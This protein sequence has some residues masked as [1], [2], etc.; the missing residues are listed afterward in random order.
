MVLLH[1]IS[2]TL[3]KTTSAISH[4]IYCRNTQEA[5]AA[6]VLSSCYC[7]PV[8]PS[9]HCWECEILLGTYRFATALI[10]Q[11]SPLV[12][13]AVLHASLCSCSSCY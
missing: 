12:D 8:P 11:V 7:A 4:V 5:V 13:F 9:F 10:K 6:N 1:V 2:F 3:R